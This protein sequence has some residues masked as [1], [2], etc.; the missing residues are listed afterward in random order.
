MSKIIKMAEKYVPVPLFLLFLPI[1]LL[2]STFLPRCESQAEVN[3]SEKLTLLQIKHDFGNPQSLDAWNNTTSV[4]ICNWT[5]IRCDADGSVVNITLSDQNIAGPLPPSICDLTN[6]T[7]LDLY[8][9]S[10][11][12]GFPSLLYNCSNLQYLDLSQN[13]LVGDLPFDI[14]RLPPKLTDLILSG[15]NFT[16][17]I[18]TSIGG[19]PEIRTLCL[20]Y[21]LFNGILPAEIGNLST[22]EKLW[23]ANNPFP[24][25]VTIPPEFGNLTRLTDLW[26]R[27]VN[28]GG[29]IPESFGNLVAI[30]QLDLSRN[31][32]SGRIPDGI[33]AL[34]NLRFLFLYKNQ[35]SGGINGTAVEAFGLESIDVSIN[36]LTGRIPEKFG[37]MNKLSVLLMYFNR[38]SGEI[39]AS[40]ALAPSLSDLR[41]FNNSLSGVLPPELGKH[42]PLWNV[43]VDDNLLSGELP[44][45]LCAGGALVS[46][47]VFNNNFSGDLPAALSKCPTLSNFMIYNNNFSGEVPAGFWTTS[48]NLTT[49]MV[50]ENSLSGT[51][52]EVLPWSLMRLEIQNNQFYGNLPSTAANLIVFKASDNLLS[53]SIPAKL[54]DFSKLTILH[55]GSNKITGGIPPEISALRYLTDL[56]L[57]SNQLVGEIPASIGT[58]PDLTSL[59]LSN[60]QLSGP[61]PQS[62]ASLNLN[63]LNLSSNKLAGEVPTTLQNQAYGQSFISNPGLCSSDSDLHITTCK[64]RSDGSDGLSH[65]LRILI[66]ILIALTV[67]FSAAIF[68]FFVVK[69]RHQRLSA[70]IK[71]KWKMTPFRSLDFTE[72]AIIRGLA[73]E[74][75]VGRGGSGKVY[76]VAAG[77]PSGSVVAVKKIWS[78]RKLDR[79]L[80]KE[81][82]TEARILGSIRHTNIVR[83]LCIL[84]ADDASLLLVYEYM[85]NGSLHCWLHGGHR[86]LDWPSRMCVAIGAAQAL[87]YMHH[88]CSPPVVHRDVKSSNILLDSSLKPKVADFG[89]ARLMAQSGQQCSTAM[90]IGSFG[91]MAPECG[92]TNK[93]NE[94]V[95]VYSFGVVLLELITGREASDGGQHDSLAEWARHRFKDGEKILDAVDHRIGGTV[96]LDEIGMVFKL[97]IFCTRRMPADRPSM[98]QV[99]QILQQCEPSDGRPCLER[100]ATPLLQNKCNTESTVSPLKVDYDSMVVLNIK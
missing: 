43:E 48:V 67:V 13:L 6:L 82:E 9:N 33:W 99:L 53:G 8:N 12:G 84:S 96:S 69:H 39:P 40:I 100:D 63:L 47:I 3:K 77:V 49:V 15:N 58:L 75:L 24:A 31:S 74:N 94:K 22:L 79:K 83:L 45:D 11:S 7:V 46:I 26:M 35:L 64:S 68:A 89:L 60:N 85:A 65:G 56:N 51:L 62:I 21:N 57:S 2:S 73:E 20:D 27:Q 16:G 78:G 36:Q 95:D 17:D 55:L 61:I 19:L 59:D 14:H 1:L 92:Y 18:P 98:K 41:L 10:I 66:A 91:Y 87:S 4:N 30:E 76:R 23:L 34:H 42:S 90:V 71:T 25:T 86:E 50:G 29:E 70:E 88:E 97:A 81:F 54:G 44:S 28:L 5:G 32:L 72:D 37:E 38:F 52:P 80:V 93:V